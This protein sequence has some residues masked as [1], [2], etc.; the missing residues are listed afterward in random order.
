MTCAVVIEG[1]SLS[2]TSISRYDAGV[3]S[4]HAQN[5]VP[6]V[7][8]KRVRIHVTCTLCFILFLFL[9]YFLL[10]SYIL[11]KYM[12]ALALNVESLVLGPGLGLE[13]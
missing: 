5:G 4:C 1:G 12:K 3:Y 9:F 7:A 8:S 11:M 10:F 6:P 2:L 13:A